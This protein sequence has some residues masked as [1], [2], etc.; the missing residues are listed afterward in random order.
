MRKIILV[1]VFLT[2]FVLFAQK[3]SKIID[4]LHVVTLQ[5]FK[6]PS[7]RNI[8]LQN[9]LGVSVDASILN[10]SGNF[11]RKAKEVWQAPNKKE[12]AKEVRGGRGVTVQ[13]SFRD[14]LDKPGTYFMDVKIKIKDE[15]RRT[16]V[17]PAKYMIVVDY[18]TLA[19]QIKLRKKGPYYFS[20]KETFSFATI[21]FPDPN[22]YSYQILTPSGRVIQQGLGSVVVLDTVFKDLNNVGK[23]L[24]IKGMYAGKEFYYHENGNNEPQLS[25]WHVMLQ[26]PEINYFGDWVEASVKND[27]PVVL[28]VYNENVKKMLFT[29][30]NTT[31][32]GNF[33]FVAP[34]IRNL[35]LRCDPEGLV[36]VRSHTTVG[37]FTYIYLDF[38]QEMLNAIEDCGQLDGVKLHIEFNTQF[39]KVTD[40]F[41]PTTI[42]K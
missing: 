13:L 35:T 11:V 28:S 34:Q 14:A 7:D 17:I 30:G 9:I 6:V 16:H 10:E 2:P 42:I 32:E 20:E 23:K 33:V 24:T 4:T 25:E 41:K 19:A 39:G 5:K 12:F 8:V 31:V 18:P 1:L 37:V 29:Y 36:T 22:K 40:D 15:N 21:E 26:A 38:N 27:N 3:G